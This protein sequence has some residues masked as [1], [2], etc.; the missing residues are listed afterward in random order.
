VEINERFEQYLK[1][2]RSEKT[3]SNYLSGLRTV[4]K[5]LCN[6]NLIE[7]NIYLINNVDIINNLLNLYL[8]VPKLKEKDI[9]GKKMY[10][11]AIKHYI[12]FYSLNNNVKSIE[13]KKINS[14]K[15]E[16]LDFLNANRLENNSIDNAEEIDNISYK[17]NTLERETII[18]SRIGQ[19]NYRKSL[20]N[21]YKRCLVCGISDERFLIASHIKSWSESE[22][23]EKLDI[24]NGLLLCVHHD[25]L[26]D[27]NLITFTDT[28]DIVISDEVSKH[29]QQLLNINENTKL[30]LELNNKTKKYLEFH[31]EKLLNK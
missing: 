6:A 27:K 22:D 25:A 9:R 26:F 31:R 15:S 29:T 4:S 20:I 18:K 1:K 28:G 21:K 30:K 17:I 3:V 2:N 11:H 7:C 5:E 16:V 19:S 13:S 12:K 8:S 14:E 10:R 23:N 24:N